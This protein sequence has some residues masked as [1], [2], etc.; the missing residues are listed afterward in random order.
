VEECDRPPLFDLAPPEP[1]ERALLVDVIPTL[2]G[3]QRVLALRSSFVWAG[4][5]SLYVASEGSAS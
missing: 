1:E 4:G 2:R 5:S 3:A